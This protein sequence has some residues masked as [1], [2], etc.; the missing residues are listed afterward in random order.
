MWD[1]K[2][3]FN[4]TRKPPAIETVFLAQSRAL[5][6]VMKRQADTIDRMQ[7]TLDRIVTAKY[8][9]P[10]VPMIEKQE[11]AN[12]PLFA[13]NDQDDPSIEAG[14]ASLTVDSDAEFLATVGVQ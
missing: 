2:R 8:D 14:I 11:S 12:M 4:I 7:E 6:E 9:R 10:V 1:W 13:L 5:A 3:L